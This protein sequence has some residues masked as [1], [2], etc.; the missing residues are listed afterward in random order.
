[1]E[2]IESSL[3]KGSPEKVF[4]PVKRR[5]VGRSGFPNCLK[6][7]TTCLRCSLKLFERELR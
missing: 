3:V 5:N 1:M 6:T 2:D 7:S 4:I